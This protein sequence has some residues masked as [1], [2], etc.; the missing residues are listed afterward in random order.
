MLHSS[1]K[2]AFTEFFVTFGIDMLI[3]LYKLQFIAVSTT[4]HLINIKRLTMSLHF[5]GFKLPEAVRIGP[6]DFRQ[7]FLS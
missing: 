6:G 5:H 2:L 7:G 1:D 3:G 4:Q